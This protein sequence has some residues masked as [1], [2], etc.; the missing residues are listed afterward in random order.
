[1]GLREILDTIILVL[2]AFLFFEA[3]TGWMTSSAIWIYYFFHNWGILAGSGWW[4]ALFIFWAIFNLVWFC[5]G[6]FFWL[7]GAAVSSEGG[8]GPIVPL[9][10]LS[11]GFIQ[12]ALV[13]SYLV[14][15][16]GW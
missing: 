3:M 9:A 15:T 16:R 8:P 6:M 4:V 1:M 12:A 5:V 11:G 7:F 2:A 10:I 13:F 14:L